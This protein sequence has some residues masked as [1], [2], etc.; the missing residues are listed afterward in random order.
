MV[1]TPAL[2]G[3]C[4]LKISQSKD[5]KHSSTLHPEDGSANEQGKFAC[6]REAAY[7]ETKTV[8]FPTTMKC[9][10]CTLQWAWETYAGTFFQCVDVT[11]VGAVD[12]EC[13]G[14]C[15]NSGICIEGVCQCLSTY[16]GDFCEHAYP[17]EDNISVIGYF[18]MFISFCIVFSLLAAGTYFYFSPQNLPPKLYSWLEVNAPWCIRH[19][20]LIEVEEEHHVEEVPEGS[21]HIVV[22]TTV[23]SRL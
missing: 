6:G 22:K 23:E 17:T 7:E 3:N 5:F 4:T 11:L 2:A 19:E 9:T 14:K 16:Y 20:H 1:S 15:Q 12:D 10:P 13:L 8:R 18:V 21:K